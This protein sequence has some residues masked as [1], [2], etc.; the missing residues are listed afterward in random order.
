MKKIN[1]TSQARNIFWATLSISTL[2]T[3]LMIVT[4]FSP[5][6]FILMKIAAI[7]LFVAGSFNLLAAAVEFYKAI[8]NKESYKI[9]RN[10]A[11]LLLL[12]FPIGLSYFCLIV[13]LE[14]KF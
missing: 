12:N 2:L 14:G 4:S 3:S 11:L 5:T 1:F 6:G 9:H 8:S 13:F 10:S 7:Y